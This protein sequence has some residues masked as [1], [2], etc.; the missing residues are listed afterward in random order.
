MGKVLRALQKFAT[1]EHPQRLADHVAPVPVL[2]LFLLLTT[3][4][5][6]APESRHRS[7][8]VSA[9]GRLAFPA[10]STQSP[11]DHSESRNRAE[12][13]QI[14]PYS[15]GASMDTLSMASMTSW[16]GRPSNLRAE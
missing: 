16:A 15:E 3:P 9:S 11:D 7:L 5:I 1:D 8:T 6:T 13:H 14:Y 4:S 10:V 2:L 12:T